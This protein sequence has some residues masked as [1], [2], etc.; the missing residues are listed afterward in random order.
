MDR[1]IS[2][3]AKVG[4]TVRGWAGERLL[5]ARIEVTLVYSHYYGW[6][7]AKSH[8]GDVHVIMIQELVKSNNCLSE[9][10]WLALLLDTLFCPLVQIS[11]VRGST[12][13]RGVCGSEVLCGEL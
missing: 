5:A 6:L 13:I 12:T 1:P 8:E 2:S 3:L 10:V 4:F 9:F 11:L 7:Q